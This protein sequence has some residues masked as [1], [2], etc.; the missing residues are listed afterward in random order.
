[1]P[2]RLDKNL[3]HLENSPGTDAPEHMI[4]NTGLELIEGKEYDELVLY[5]VRYY[6]VLAQ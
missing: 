4:L 1:M 5:C 6:E 2:L 3:L